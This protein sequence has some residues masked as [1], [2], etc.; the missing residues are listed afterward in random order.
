MKFI[1][2]SWA[3]H[4]D[5]KHANNFCTSSVNKSG[6]NV[7]IPSYNQRSWA[8]SGQILRHQYGISVSDVP[9]RETSQAAR[10]EER[11]KTAIFAG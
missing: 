9:P 10:S 4:A 1:P 7:T 11:G 5:Q 6:N 8:Y 2:E 3:E